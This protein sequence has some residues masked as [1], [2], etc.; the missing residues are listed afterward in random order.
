MYIPRT[1]VYNDYNNYV[2]ICYSVHYSVAQEVQRF[3]TNLKPWLDSALKGLPDSLRTVKRN[4]EN[5]EYRTCT[6]IK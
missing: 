6:P 4:G 3:S 5:K 1:D 2:S